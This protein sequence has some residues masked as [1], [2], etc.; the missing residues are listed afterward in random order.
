MNW[1][2]HKKQNVKTFQ[3]ELRAMLKKGE[4]Q[5]QQQQQH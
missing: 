3:D 1:Y 4:K 2:F 5:Q